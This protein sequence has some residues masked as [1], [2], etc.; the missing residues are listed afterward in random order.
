MKTSIDFLLGELLQN[1]L[2][3][4]RYDKDDTMNEIVAKAK[5]MHKRE[6][7]EASIHTVQYNENL[8][9]DAG[10]SIAKK[11]YQETFKK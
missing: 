2:L 10:L 5:E 3:A 11:Y 1:K 4:L 9:L 7:I 6:I 8:T